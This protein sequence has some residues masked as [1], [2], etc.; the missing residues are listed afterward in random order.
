MSTQYK[1]SKAAENDWRSIMRY[2]LSEFGEN[3]AK[4]YSADLIKCLEQ[5]SGVKNLKPS[6]TLNV[7]GKTVRVKSC[8]RHYIFALEKEDHPLIIIAILHERMDLMQRL[9]GRL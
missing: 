3:Q 8:K 7:S 1:L 4:K 6:K 5:I 2:T 9:K